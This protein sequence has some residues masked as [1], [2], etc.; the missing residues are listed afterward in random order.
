MRL[1]AG[2]IGAV[3]LAAACSNEP[4]VDD[5]AQSLVAAQPDL[6]EAGADCIVT[7]LQSSYSEAEL[8]AL[9][10]A[11]STSTDDE[12]DEFARNQLEA[13]RACDLEAQVSPALVDAFAAANSLSS[14]VAGCAVTMLQEQF[15]F[16]EL[17]D[18]LAQDLST[19]RF[20]RRQLE[21]IFECGDRTEVAR[22][23]EPQLASQGVGAADA[24]C[25]AQALA[26]SMEVAD[27]SVLY[28]G[29]TNDRFFELYFNA[30]K[31]CGA[32]PDDGSG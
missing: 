31:A 19:T 5:L 2:V 30:V 23:L 13:L 16:W 27:L 25:V 28:S 4:T 18:Q 29:Q 11:G 15:G 7:Q 24:S 26:D 17:T 8:T 14:E 1:V 21:S 12:Q 22:Q 20:Q 9:V 10:S 3:L 6:G 32:L